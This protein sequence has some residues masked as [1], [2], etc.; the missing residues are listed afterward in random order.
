[1]I[2]WVKKLTGEL[3]D[4]IEWL[5]DST[6][7]LVYRGVTTSYPGSAPPGQTSLQAYYNGNWTVQNFL[8]AGIQLYN[9]YITAYGVV[10]FFYTVQDAAADQAIIDGMNEGII[11]CAAGGNQW[12]ES[13]FLTNQ[14]DYNNTL[15]LLY[16][17]FFGIIPLYN[18]WYHNRL[19]SPAHA[20]ANTPNTAA[21]RKC[22]VSANLGTLVNEQLSDTSQSGPAIDV[23]APG[24]DIMSSYNSGVTDPRNPAYY[25]A[26]LTG[27]SMASPQ[28]AGLLACVAEQY[29]NMTQMQARTYMQNFRNLNAMFDPNIQLP[30]NNPVRSLRGADNAILTYYPD[31]P[32]NGNVWPQKRSWLRPSSGCVYPRYGQQ[33]RPVV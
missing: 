2:D 33:Y 3:I 27:T 21:W 11:W 25:L 22:I 10:L 31:R 30:P 13:G 20:S 14:P 26:K 9:D 28:T 16:S 32:I 17:I 8:N 12:D 7:T 29:P 4:I 1:M 19:P 15:N 24:T 6:N 18:T 23:V 5:D